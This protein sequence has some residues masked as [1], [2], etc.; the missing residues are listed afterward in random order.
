[1]HSNVIL[2]HTKSFVLRAGKITKG[3]NNALH[4]LLP[5]FGVKYVEQLVDLNQ[6]FGRNNPKVIEIG[7]GMGKATA[8]IAKVNPDI[9]YLGLEVHLPGVGSLLNELVTHN[10]TNVRVINYDGTQVIKHMLNHSS[11]S[12]FHVF[13]PDPWP[14]K[15][16]HKRRLIQPELVELLVDKLVV[17]GYIH[18]AT[19]WEHYANAML[20]V[21]MANPRL[22]NAALAGDQFIVRPE[23][24]PL[25]KF[26]AR[27]INLGHQVWDL[28]FI[29]I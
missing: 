26:E 16:H 12:G 13:F 10:L 19:D 14:K 11:I 3:Q 8:E 27:G 24:R 23:S 15:R 18:L 21:L 1:M 17:G 6:V 9:D 22:K 2:R 4:E 7:F 28:M 5:H 20:E 29:K 25:T